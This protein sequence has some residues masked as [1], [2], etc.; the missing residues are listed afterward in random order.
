MFAGNAGL[1]SDAQ[2]CL[3]FGNWDYVGFE[4]D[5]TVWSQSGDVIRGHMAALDR[6]EKEFRARI[7]ANMK[8]I[9]IMAKVKASG[10]ESLSEQEV[11]T[12]STT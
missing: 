9:P 11:P 3:E 1:A 8:L 6:K 4:R 5:T 12:E 7:K 10:T 2:A